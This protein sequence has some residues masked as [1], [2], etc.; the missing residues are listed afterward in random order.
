MGNTLLTPSII[1]KEALM[2]LENNM[3]LGAFVHRDYSNEFA[4]VGNTI[5]I[6]KPATFVANVWDGANLNIQNITE[7]NVSVVMN[8]VL[9][10]SFNISALE[11]TQNIVAFSEQVIRP[12]MQAH[13]Q[14]IDDLLAGLYIDVPYAVAVSSTANVADLANARK[15]LNQNKVPMEDRRG[16]LEPITEAKYL[17]LDAFLHAEKRGDTDAVKNGS[18]GRVLGIDWYMDQNMRTHD[19]GTTDLAGVLNGAQAKGNVS[20]VVNGLGTGN[21]TQ[22]TLLTIVNCVGVYCVKDTVAISSNVATLNIAP[23]LEAAAANAENVTLLQGKRNLVF[24]KN[25]FALVTRPLE[26]PFGAGYAAVENYKGISARVTAGYT[27][28]SKADTMSLDILLGVKT[29]TPELG[30]VLYDAN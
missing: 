16:V 21:V 18:M 12:A 28:A 7:A 25:C 2:V 9:D 27:M 15:K 13:A 29:L 23:A 17:V 19:A 14:K 20:L 11:L 30:V 22:G 5:K 3:V 10:V 1:A 24:H 26:K 6:R 4:K 8:T